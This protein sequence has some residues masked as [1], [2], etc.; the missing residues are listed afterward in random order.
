MNKLKSVMIKGIIFV[1]ILGTLLHFAYSLSGSNFIIG[2]F[3]PI[4]ESIWEHTKLIF[5]P[6]LFYSLYINK[7]QKETFPAIT[8]AMLFSS[9]LGVMLIITLFY[10]YSGILG[11]NLAIVDIS[12]FY[13]SVV[14]AFYVAY[15]L[16][17][18]EKITNHTN[19]LILLCISMVIIYMIFSVIPPEIPLFFE[20]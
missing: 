12:I 14:L 17:L 2:L 19:I 8:S 7:N 15:C 18:S 3:T 5:F 1:W 11:Y 20:P 10:T 4:N 9:F 13:A 16:T 6:M